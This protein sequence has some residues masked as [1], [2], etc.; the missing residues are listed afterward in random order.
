MENETDDIFEEEVEI[1]VN[2][3]AV[4]HTA[5]KIKV[6]VEPGS[7]ARIEFQLQKSGEIGEEIEISVMSRSPK[8]LESSYLLPKREQVC[9][10]V[11]RRQMGRAAPP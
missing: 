9:Y 2:N 4:N 1:H 10:S 6:R 8:V 5:G 7:E 3:S 11:E